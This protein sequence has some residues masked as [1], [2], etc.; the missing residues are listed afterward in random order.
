MKFTN[1]QLW[2]LLRSKYKSFENITSKAT[3]DTFTEKGWSEISRDN[4]NVINSFFELSLK[5]LFQKLDIAK[6]N[7]RLE[8]SGLVE[9]YGSG[10]GGFLQRISIEAIAPVSPGFINLQ[11]GD[12]ID[13]FVVRKPEAKERF[14]EVGNF[15][16]QSMITIQEYQAKSIFLAPEGMSS[17]L[18]G[19]LAGLE[20][21]YKQQKE[22]NCYKAIHECINSSSAPLQDT[23]KLTLTSWTDGAVTEAELLDFLTQ[24]QDTATAMDTC[25][26][27]PGYNANG[28]DTA[29]NKEDYILLIRSGILNQIKRMKALNVHYEGG[30]KMLEIPF[31]T[32]EVNDFGGLKY[33]FGDTTDYPLYPHYAQNGSVDGWALS[34]G[35]AKEKELNDPA[36]RCVDED[37]A[38]LGVIA[39]KGLIFEDF[40]E[41][42]TVQTIYNPRGLY[43][44]YFASQPNATIKYDAN[45]GCIIIQKPGAGAKST[46]KS[47]K[48][49]T[50]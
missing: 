11:N 1:Q 9:K 27:Q 39:Q 48:K 37:S 5:V 7:T 14:F 33:Y 26:T 50:K 18:S 10:F 49:S 34:A 31:K 38:V 16:Y 40:R 25:I 44:N 8:E 20:A 15:Q 45:Y 32:L 12:S 6:V 47:T 3:A 13:P 4:I 30:D 19:I 23:Q 42:Y 22:L 28:F 43:N 35:G 21:G 36:V 24:V 29:A 41:P 2:D 46:T 17:F